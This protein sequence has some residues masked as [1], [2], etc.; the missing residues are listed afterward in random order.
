MLGIKKTGA[1]PVPALFTLWIDALKSRSRHVGHGVFP[2]SPPK[3]AYG[4][5]SPCG[6]KIHDRPRNKAIVARTYWSVNEK[7][8]LEEKKAKKS[9]EKDHPK[10][11][12]VSQIGPAVG[13]KGHTGRV[14]GG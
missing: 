9:V 7:Q 3:P 6:R 11:R 4:T 5:G 2:Q 10:S 13:K 14:V 8:V 12:G 1:K